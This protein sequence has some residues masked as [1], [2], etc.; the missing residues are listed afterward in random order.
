M[1]GAPGV[2]SARV[3]LQKVTNSTSEVGLI[4]HSRKTAPF[5]GNAGGDGFD[6]FAIM[7]DTEKLGGTG[8]A[9]K[10][11]VLPFPAGLE[12]DWGDG[13]IDNLNTHT[14]VTGGEHFIQIFV[15]VTDWVYQN[16][17]DKL[18]LVDVLS[19]GD[20]FDIQDSGAFHGCEN[21]VWTTTDTPLISTTDL[22]NSWNNC[23]LFNG[24]LDKCDTRLVTTM[25]A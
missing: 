16:G 22:S 12:V 14:Y 5:L 25:A 15:P 4:H 21:M 3:G 1:L 17:G 19:L 11:A 6:H 13:I 23:Q 24:N 10:T 7:Y 20:G 2:P 9:T 18:K 8:S